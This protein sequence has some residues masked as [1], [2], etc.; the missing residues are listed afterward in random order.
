M[1]GSISGPISRV[2]DFRDVQ[3]RVGGDL[4]NQRC[5]VGAMAH[6]IDGWAVGSRPVT[7]VCVIENVF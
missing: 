1:L 6:V 2:E 4:K 3:R 7:A 5:S